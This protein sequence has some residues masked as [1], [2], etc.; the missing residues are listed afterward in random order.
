[1]N[2]SIQEADKEHFPEWCQ[3]RDALFTGL[4]EDF[5]QQ[6]MAL[7]FDAEDRTCFMAYNSFNE[8]IGFIELSLRNLVDGCL[9]SPVGYI[10][11]I[12]LQPEDRSVGTGRQL[13]NWAETWFKEKGCTEM[14]TD[15]E[16]NNLDAQK[17]HERVGFKETYRI[18]Q[19]KKI[20]NC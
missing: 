5:H 17:F 2:I 20:L 1:M 9:S 15:A 6:E 13:I 7:I 14:A 12:Y 19:Y 3:M 18:V 16:I 10:E 4:D 8:P 11:G